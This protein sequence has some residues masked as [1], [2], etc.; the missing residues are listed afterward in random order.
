MDDEY[1]RH[2][3]ASSRRSTDRTKSLTICLPS[4]CQS[5]GKLD[6]PANL[7][8]LRSYAAIAHFSARNAV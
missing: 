6:G 7:P 5:N 3:A 1:I 2:S 4:D 8:F